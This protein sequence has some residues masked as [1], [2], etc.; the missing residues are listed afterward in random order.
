M[1]GPAVTCSGA[2]KFSIAD[3]IDRLP[4]AGPVPRPVSAVRLFLVVIT[5]VGVVMG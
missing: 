5:V 2:I 3:D 1:V 4:A